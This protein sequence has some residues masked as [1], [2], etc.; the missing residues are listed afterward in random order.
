MTGPQLGGLRD[1]LCE[2]FDQDSFDQLL[3]I[4]LDVDREQVVGAGNK[5]SVVFS[6]LKVAHRKGWLPDLVRAA[7]AENPGNPALRKW[8]DEN[9]GAAVADEATARTPAMASEPADLRR[10]PVVLAAPGDVALERQAVRAFF[11]RF[12]RTT[13]LLW[14]VRF[15]VAG[16]KGGAAV[17]SAPSRGA[18]ARPLL[19][20]PGGPPAFVVGVLWQRF[21]SS[22]GET[23]SGTAEEFTQ[24]LA[25][26]RK[27]DAPATRWFFRRVE[28]FVAPADLD[29]LTRAV[30]QWSKVQ[31]FRAR[32]GAEGVP[33]CEYPDPAGFRDVLETDLN[34]WL[35]Q[36]GQ[37]WSPPPSDQAT[38]SL[39]G[40]TPPTAYYRNIY[41]DFYRLDIAGIDNDRTFEIPLSDVYVRLRVKCD[42]DAPDSEAA[43][44][45]PIDI[46][47]ALFRYKK[48][49]IVGDPGSGKST[50]LKYIAL[51]LAK[52]VTEDNPAL[53]QEKLCLPEPLP[54]PVFVSCWD[55]S[56]FLAGREARLPALLEF[57]SGR[58]AA[59][60]FN[61]PVA[62]LEQLLEV[63]RCG[64]LFDG[65]D[66]VPTDQ[67]RTAVSRLLEDCVGR[68][69]KNR[70]VVTS[71]VRAYTGD[72]IL[73]GA[74]TRC[75]IE[76]FDANDR[77]QF[78]RN[79][80]ALL[81][82]VPP[83]QAL[84]TGTD[85]AGEF[86][87]LT[88][89]I[90]DKDRIRN[91]AVNPLLLTVIAIVHWNRKR[92]PEQR[93]DLYDECVDVL[94]G[95][96][97]EA[98]RVQSTRRATEQNEQQEAERYEERSW[99]RKRFAEVALHILNLDGKHDE[100]T[101]EDVVKLLVPRFVDR[102]AKDAEQ[103]RFQAE[104]FLDRQELQ[105][106][107]LVSRRTQSYRFVHLTFQEYLAAWHLSN[108]EFAVVADVIRRRLREPKWFETLQLLGA[109][110]SRQSDEKI[111]L[112][113]NWLLNEQGR[114][115]PTWTPVVA[116]CANIARDTSGVASLKPQTQELLQWA[117]EE[118]LAA[119]REGSGIPVVTQLEILEALGQLGAAVKPQLVDAAGA[120]N[121]QVRR[122]AI[123]MLLR[124]L[125]EGEVF[126]LEYFREARSETI[127]DYL[128][129]LIALDPARTVGM[130][131][132]VK[133]Y[134]G[135]LLEVIVDSRDVLQRVVPADQ[136]CTLL[137][138]LGKAAVETWFPGAVDLISQ[139]ADMFPANDAVWETIRRAAV[140]A[141][142]SGMRRA[143]VE[144]LV[145]Y[146][147]D[148]PLTWEDVWNRIRGLEKPPNL[149]DTLWLIADASGEIT[150]AWNQIR[151]TAG[152]ALSPR[153][154]MYALS[155]LAK[156]F[157]SASQS[158]DFLRKR[159]TEEPEEAV[160]EH[161]SE[162]LAEYRQ[163]ETPLV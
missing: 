107:L 162:L 75:D 36:P 26:Q 21:A 5:E 14:K 48:L 33:Y 86:D 124:H 20:Q 98:E 27:Q 161:I 143:A 55:L 114:S 51:M 91:L 38:A 153:I 92:L 150:T 52:A 30:E 70:Y 65:L 116:L 7:R 95:Q 110:L 31:T 25:D 73:R 62:G 58:F 2:A 79:W 117:V 144:A 60:G 37:P 3:R 115:I 19:D 138:T 28:Q 12:N 104:R 50:F 109:E 71:R 108:Q 78:L 158:W 40:V 119:F 9:P 133:P 46:Q 136:L 112:Y 139:L 94:L 67:R 99:V 156:R 68:Y 53:A 43:D 163:R 45:G 61:L 29:T 13:G 11:D 32:V 77:A 155:L 96:R 134:S 145:R 87:A 49:V 103:A 142:N 132:G 66:E 72:T 35:F 90:E 137:I 24:I 89:A 6:F 39:P 157:R 152:D 44:G 69:G 129:A 59:Y 64:L 42:E 149:A 41:Q 101:K 80:V 23:E 122:R 15:E 63:G 126:S 111:D 83:A 54:V 10:F 100:A 135:K 97:K 151:C 113:I 74:F 88:Q 118:T 81:F 57:I 123:E 106:G 76:P 140:Q 85:A 121:V 131:L 4:H 160:R 56:D 127:K 18:T 47:T 17:G 147:R 120:G 125:P 34:R 159:V 22:T 93:V 130:L 146:K 16:G 154:R 82:R 148:D 141:E 1:A 8:C 128:A 84:D 105:S 102:G